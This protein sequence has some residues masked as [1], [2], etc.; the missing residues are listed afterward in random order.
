M[1]PRLLIVYIETVK[2]SQ[3]GELGPLLERAEEESQRQE[4][5]Q[6]QKTR[7]SGQQNTH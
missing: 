6:L 3:L 2:A 1:S 4:Q 5:A 7:R